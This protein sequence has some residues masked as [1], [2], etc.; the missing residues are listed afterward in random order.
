MRE[1]DYLSVV[2]SLCRYVVTSFL[3]SKLFFPPLAY[4][5]ER[6]ETIYLPSRNVLVRRKDVCIGILYTRGVNS[7]ATLEYLRKEIRESKR[8]A[9][10]QVGKTTGVR[11]ESKAIVPFDRNDVE[12]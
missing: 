3:E 4:R 1:S 8:V 10:S 7:F 6:I 2:M 11:L 9:P 5:Y 12:P